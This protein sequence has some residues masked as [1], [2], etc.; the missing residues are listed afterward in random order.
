MPL[1]RRCLTLFAFALA[2]VPAVSASVQAID[3]VVTTIDGKKVAGELYLW[4]PGVIV[5]K[6]PDNRRTLGVKNV[7]EVRPAEKPKATGKSAL[8]IQ[9]ADG[10][11]IPFADLMVTDRVAEI[12]TP[13]STEPLNIPA[14]ALSYVTFEKNAPEFPADTTSDF[15]IVKKKDSEE[16][17]TLFGVI[18]AITTDQVK[19]S[20]DGDTI[21]VK[22]SKLAGLGF[23]Q[24]ESENTTKPQCWLNLASGAKLAALEVNREGESLIATLDG[25][26]KVS[27]PL[28]E[29]ESADYSVG[30][31][32]YLSDMTPLAKRWTPLVSLPL[33]AETIRNFGEPRQN[34]SFTGSPLSLRWPAGDAGT[35]D[36]VE[37]YNKGLAIRSRTNLEY[38]IPKAMRRFV[39]L[40]GIDPETAS[41]GHVA[42]TIEVDGESV[43]DEVI[44][45]D[46][47]PR[48]I[49]ID[50]TDK[51]RLRIFVDYGENLDLGDRLHLVEAR[52]I[53]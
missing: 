11:R 16:T 23:Y 28:A 8:Q 21:P 25:D 19:F 50:I 40:A 26:L 42:V 10:S 22:R 2:I 45:G 7:L 32:S 1:I 15:L 34:M 20:W 51:Q 38:R 47:T 43:F 33:A 37:T 48:E 39:A 30:K 17:E 41:Q 12:T 52:L 49:D 53:K 9:L 35:G 44:A 6:Q 31:L 14:G 18:D 27:V 5:I 13:L 46:Q 29:I 36:R 3:M 24:A 4:Q